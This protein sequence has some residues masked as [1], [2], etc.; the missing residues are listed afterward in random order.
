MKSIM[1]RKDGTC[2]LCMML[3]GNFREQVVEEHHVFMGHANRQLAEKYGLKVYLCAYH[4]RL[5]KMSVHQNAT[6]S[7]ML[8]DK[9][10]RAFEACYPDLDFRS[11]FGRNYKT[12]QEEKTKGEETNGFIKLT[13]MGDRDYENDS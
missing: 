12:D 8:Q 2:Y 7:R 11:I 5:G 1:Q 3:E 13:E 6:I 4:H 10:Q 9:G